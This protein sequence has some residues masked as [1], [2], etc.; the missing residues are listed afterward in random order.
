MTLRICLLSI[1]SAYS[2]LRRSPDVCHELPRILR[3]KVL[4]PSGRPRTQPS[5][6]VAQLGPIAVPQARERPTHSIEGLDGLTSSLACLM[7]PPLQDPDAHQSPFVL[8][9]RQQK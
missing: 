1:T 5:G 4:G 2:R 9:E 6:T 8:Q 3:T 7:I